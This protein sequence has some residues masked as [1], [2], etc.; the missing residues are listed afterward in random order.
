MLTNMDALGLVLTA[1]ADPT[2]RAILQ[3]LRAQPRA[4]TAI[5]ADFKVSRPAVSQHIKILTAAGLLRRHRSGRENY[6][7]LDLRGISVLRGY[8]ESF[9][10]DVLGA[11]QAAAI[12][13]HRP[14]TR[15]KRKSRRAAAAT[16]KP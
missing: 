7:A 14:A 12:E 10:D 4:V 16:R 15:I 5:A 3:R 6:Y 2:R 13:A 1:L 8:V 11:F 9:W